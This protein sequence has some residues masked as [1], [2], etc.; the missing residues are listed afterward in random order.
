ATFSSL[1][2][3]KWATGNGEV[4]VTQAGLTLKGKASADWLVG[5][6]PVVTF[7]GSVSTGETEIA[8]A[9]GTLDGKKIVFSA[10][11]QGNAT[12]ANTALTL[13]GAVTGAVYYGADQTGEKVKNKA[14]TEVAA[15]QGDWLIDS[16]SATVTVKGL[17]LVGKATVG[18]VGGQTWVT[19]GGSV[20]FT[21]NGTN[22]KGSATADWIV[23]KEPVVTYEGTV[24][25]DGVTF[26]GVRG[27]L[28]STKLTFDGGANL[29][30][31]GIAVKGQVTGVVYLGS[32][33]TGQKIRNAAG[34]EVTPARGDVF[35]DSA[36]A[37]I[38]AKG[39]TVTAAAQ[40]G[41]VGGKLWVEGLGTLEATFG[42]TKVDGQASISWA[43]GG[44]PSVAFTGR[45]TS[46]DTIV[47]NAAGIIDGKKIA[48]KGDATL[49]N[50]KFTLKGAA[51]GVLF[52]GDDLT[53]ELV[54]DRSGQKV[55]PSKGDFTIV[56]ASGEAVVQN[57]TLKGAV[58]FTSL[59]ATKW[60]T[61][62][63]SVDF[64]TAGYTLKG[65][66]D[67]DWV[68][69][70][71]PVVTFNGSFKSGDTE[72]ASASGTLDGKKIALTGAAKVSSTNVTLEGS[73]SGV[74][75]YAADQTGETIKNKAGASV[76]AK[77]GD[78]L[79]TSATA[80][81][82][83]K[84]FVLTGAASAGRVGTQAWVTGGGSVDVTYGTINVKG[85]AN[86]DW[87]VGTSPV[88]NF[89]GSLKN[90]DVEIGSAKGTID[91]KK[92]TFSGTAKIS[93]GDIKVNG[94]VNGGVLY[95]GNSLTGETIKN[96][97]GQVVPATKG[98]LRI[99]SAAADVTVKNLTFKANVEIGIVGT[100]KWAKGTGSVDATFGSTKL[101]GSADF[102]WT[103]GNT[104]TVAFTGGIANGAA[105]VANA[106]GTLDG[107]KITLKGNVTATTSSLT[108]KGAVDGVFFYGADQTGELVAN[109]AGVKVQPLQGD[110]LL[111]NASGSVDA[112]G[113][114][115]AGGI[116]VGNV[117]GDW[118]ATAGGSIDISF[119]QPV[120]RIQGTA[121]MKADGNVAFEG[122]LTN[123]D[124]TA[125]VTG[126]ADG[127]KITFDGALSNPML[128][129]KASGYVYYG[130]NLAGETVVNRAGQTVAATRGDFK[131][132][133]ADGSLVLK[134]L[135]VA[136]AQASLVKAGTDLWI[137]GGGK[138]KIAQTW[139][140]FTGQAD[141]TG[142]ANL[143][144]SGTVNFDGTT[145][146]FAGTATIKNNALTIGGTVKISNGLLSATL[147]G[148]IE[149]PNMDVSQ[150]V[151]TGT[152]NF[153]FGG[154]SI[155]NAN[156]K[157]IF[158][159]GLITTFDIKS[160]FVIFICP[161][162]TYKVYFSGT[163]V[164]KVE[165][166]SPV[167]WVAQ[168]T[169]IAALAAPGAQIS[170]KITGI[171]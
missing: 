5:E 59:G 140:T 11:A 82:T 138:I 30:V 85:S 79:V 81:V 148:T 166:N 124:T 13:K 114:S 1:G 55:Q 102:D 60:A 52:Y 130:E 115:L 97:A 144:G 107:K 101:S 15:K 40:F 67:A 88:L 4:N 163:K 26:A 38:S 145:V 155:V 29:T 17:T 12:I 165:I 7:E 87:I 111:T 71:S 105:I 75:H 164:S 19:A 121:S 80:K 62:K 147:T 134:Q 98:D 58:S 117:R 8:G 118:W 43:Q 90:S 151:F 152:A 106:A 49:T 84:G 72:I 93:T 94:S 103:V 141:N 16:A 128:S 77:Q 139:I 150:Y 125:N 31:S 14:G 3:E 73:A 168:F 78:F 157:L 2:T 69:G 34:N 57:L 23:G 154:F 42:A 83:A 108:V 156:V 127:K 70:G 25:R 142:Y 21:Y 160:C 54:T 89:E 9:K 149:K 86:V 132:D 6:S 22:I 133:V 37:Q 63:G 167:A 44:A 65:S 47:A 112:K 36:A 158:G 76:A 91:D 136:N 10:S 131:V 100:T 20:D 143:T 24:A 126:T 153:K 109:R 18:S 113:L 66:A 159:E 56:S 61:A 171:I 33:L 64:S 68:V 32:D 39:V 92:I 169:A 27:T 129:G 35:V 53:G 95:Y 104:P 135:T 99:D 48:I 45:L 74:V 119:G 137:K 122:K 46:G 120:T 161:N 51:E 110:Y 96:K 50:P 146:D 162:A 28:D 123:Q 41:Y 170:P 116:S